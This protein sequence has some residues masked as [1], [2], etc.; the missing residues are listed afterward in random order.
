L[1]AGALLGYLGGR[2]LDMVLDT[3]PWLA[4]LGVT[5]G[6]VTAF[7]ALVQELEPG[8]FGGDRD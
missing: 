2:R 8:L 6:L 7:L 5:V 1:P 4:L 3:S